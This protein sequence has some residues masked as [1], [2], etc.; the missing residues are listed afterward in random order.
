MDRI[1]RELDRVRPYKTIVFTN[2]VFD[3]LH[4]GHISLLNAAKGMGDVLVVGVNSDESTRRLQKGPNRPLNPLE[5]RMA[6]L[7]ALKMVD[8]VIPFEEGTPIQLI[9]KV[10]P[11][12]H[13]K[14]GDYRA[15]DLAE[16]E[17]LQSLHALIA[18]VPTVAGRSSTRIIEQLNPNQ[19]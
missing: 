12:V 6:L 15:E 14:G 17:V 3:V 11:H 8:Y 13:V 1:L 9:E 19:K 16:F 18:I 10:R 4:V 7:N 2:G 5:D